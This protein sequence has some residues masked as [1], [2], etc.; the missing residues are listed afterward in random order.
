VCESRGGASVWCGWM[1]VHARMCVCVCA[2]KSD[3][4]EWVGRGQAMFE[5][6]PTCHILVLHALSDGSVSFYSLSPP[7]FTALH[8]AD[9]V[10]GAARVLPGSL[11]WLP[12]S[13][14]SCLRCRVI[15][16]SGGR[17]RCVDGWQG[18]GSFVAARRAD[19]LLW[20]TAPTSSPS[21]NSFMSGRR[22]STTQIWNFLEVRCCTPLRCDLVQSPS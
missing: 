5:S 3:G 6:Y 7:V 10:R 2:E 16:R 17:S 1:C 20:D 14:F 12:W 18:V 21:R 15:W 22:P 13:S 19:F 4:R 11:S 9:F 8:I